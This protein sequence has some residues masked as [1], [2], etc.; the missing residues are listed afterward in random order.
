MIVAV[1]SC[2]LVRL[3][4]LPIEIT[5]TIRAAEETKTTLQLAPFGR[6]SRDEYLVEVLRRMHAFQL[7]AAAVPDCLFAFVGDFA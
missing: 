7:P 4:S 6:V 5:E 3:E 2:T 1:T